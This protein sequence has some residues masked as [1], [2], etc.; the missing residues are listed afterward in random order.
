MR[1]VRVWY[2]IFVPRLLVIL[3]LV[4][5]F[6]ARNTFSKKVL[7]SVLH[8][9]NLGSSDT[10]T[11]EQN[12]II[13]TTCLKKLTRFSSRATMFYCCFQP[14][15]DVGTIVCRSAYR[16]LHQLVDIQ[17]K[18]C[19][20]LIGII[21]RSTDHGINHHQQARPADRSILDTRQEGLS[22][23]TSKAGTRSAHRDHRPFVTH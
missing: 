17:M 8:W 19:K 16:H 12:D 13:K 3:I 15:V 5:S 20:K 22:A 18:H 4:E 6:T 23:D 7:L 1:C 21:T 14:D 2:A 9:S 11:G 10:Q